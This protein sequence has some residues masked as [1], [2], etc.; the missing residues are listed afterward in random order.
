MLYWPSFSF[1][2]FLSIIKYFKKSNCSYISRASKTFNTSKKVNEFCT[3]ICLALL[4][5]L[6]NPKNEQVKCVPCVIL[7]RYKQSQN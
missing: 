4:F 6:F 5:S 7:L 2:V 1:C 3:A